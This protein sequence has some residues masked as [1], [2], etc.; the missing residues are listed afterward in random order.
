MRFVSEGI[1]GCDMAVTVA[2][3]KMAVQG[4]FAW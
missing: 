2:A 3:I 4:K 1:V